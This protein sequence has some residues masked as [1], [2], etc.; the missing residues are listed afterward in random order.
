MND[1]KTKI[2]ATLGPASA[3]KEVLREMMLSGMDVC[4]LN[5]S[6][7]NYEFYVKLI[8]TIRELNEE[9]GHTT[10]ILA[11]LQGPKM[12]VGEMENGPIELVDGSELIITN[13]Q[14]KGR[15]GIVSTRH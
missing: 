13:E 15:K 2:V 10:A 14:I 5:F 12:R 7:G 3:A 1:P 8:A 9:L 6:H 11:D 4:R